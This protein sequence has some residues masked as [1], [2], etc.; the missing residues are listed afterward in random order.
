MKISVK[1]LKKII[2]EIGPPIK[3]KL[4]TKATKTQFDKPALT[5]YVTPVEL[6]SIVN[7]AKPSEVRNYDYVDI[8][9]G[10]VYWEAGTPASE[11]RFSAYYRQNLED[12][13]LAKEKANAEE[14]AAWAEE[15][16]A[17]QKQ[18]DEELKLVSDQLMS[19]MTEYANNAKADA[20]ATYAGED[21]EMYAM[22]LAQ[23]FLYTYPWQSAAKKLHMSKDDIVSFIADMIAS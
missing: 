1:N 15:D 12:E 6:E 3:S 16:A 21:I 10:E 14:E 23:G 19:A 20:S 13:K 11:C 9:T 5:V 7:F 2:K 4:A 8:D 17:Y 22:D 18:N